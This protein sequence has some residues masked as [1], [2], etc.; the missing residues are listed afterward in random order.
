[1]ASTIKQDV[2]IG[3]NFRLLRKKNGYSEE[4]VAAKL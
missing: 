3:K 1:M 2:S 4:G